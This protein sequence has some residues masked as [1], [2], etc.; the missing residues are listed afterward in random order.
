MTGETI[1][2]VG[3]G[4][5]GACT[6]YFLSQRSDRRVVVFERDEVAAETTAKS[7]GYV[8]VRASHTEAHRALLKRSIRLYN[9]VIREADVDVQH[10]MLGGLTV[11]TTADG[12]AALRGRHRSL[13]AD[14]EG[15]NSAFTKFYDGKELD[16]SLLIPDFRLDNFTAAWFWPNYGYVTPASLAATFVE[17]ARD[18]GAVFRTNASVHELERDATGSIEAVQTDRGRTPVNQLVL[19]AGPWNPT[20]AQSVGV[21]LPVRH[22]FAPGVLLDR[23]TGNRHP[24]LTHHESGVYLRPHGEHQLFAGHYQGDYDDAAADVADP[25]I[26]EAVPNQLR[27][28]ILDAVGR[29]VHGLDDPTVSDQWVGL[30]SLTPDGN[31][32]VGWTDVEGLFVATYNAT[33][34]QHAPAV[35]HVLSRQILQGDPTQHYDSVSISR[36][37][38]HS[39]V[40]DG[41]VSI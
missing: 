5:T 12:R 37:E 16:A 8:G 31:P 21:D 4:I 6:A 7:A 9:E 28:E 1:G 26:P 22:S 23:P 40:H 17:R 36:F 20:L 39:D 11:A 27:Q 19:A 2:I 10:R 33:G 41:S 24:S 32:I 35:G 25:K 38:G 34:I 18:A 3:A 14:D 30:R 15:P 29:L 13:G